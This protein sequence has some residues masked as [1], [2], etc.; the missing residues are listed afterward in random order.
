MRYSVAFFAVMLRIG[1][2]L[3]FF[4]FYASRI[5]SDGTKKVNTF[6]S[7]QSPFFSFQMKKG[8]ASPSPIIA[9]L[10]GSLVAFGSS[11]SKS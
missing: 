1:F 9:Y 6:F 3:A 2:Y 8:T 4:G 7:I 10:I 11:V 5:V